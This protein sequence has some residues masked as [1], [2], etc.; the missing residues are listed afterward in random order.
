MATDTSARLRELRKHFHK[1]DIGLYVVLTQDEHNSEYTSD[2]DE[3]RA[4]ISG[5]TGSAGT[6]VIS[7]TKAVLATDGRYFLQA[8]KQLS[9]DWQLLKQG[10]KGVPTWSEWAAQEAA[11]TGTNIGVDPKLISYGDVKSL[12]DLLVKKGAK[13]TLVGLETN[14]I[15]AVWGADKPQRSKKPVFELPLEHTGRGFEDKISELRKDIEKLDGTAF[16]VSAL[17]EI[18]WLFNLR[19]EDIAYN[20]VFFSYAIVSPDSATLYIDENKLSEKVRAHLGDDVT[21]KPYQQVF[22]DARKFSV[23]LNEI[24]ATAA[25]KKKLL[26]AN[27]C[28]WALIKALG[29]ADNVKLVNSPVEVAKAAKNETEVNGARTAHVKDGV[30]LIRYLSWLEDALKNGSKMSD[31]EAAMKSLEFRKQME[32]F[33][34]LSFET[35]S[36]SGP[37]AAIIHYSPATDSKEMV[38]INQVYLLDSGGQYLEGTTDTTRTFHFGTPSAEEK[39]AFTLVLKGHIA[40][41]EAVFPEGSNGYM[42]DTLARQHLWKYG[43]DYRHG[44]GHG[45]GAYLNVHEGPIGVG[46][47]PGYRENPF[48]VGNVIS[49]EPGYYEDGKFG[50]R[51]ESVVVVKEKKTLFNFGDVKYFGFETITQVPLCK[52]LMDIDLLTVDEKK[53]VNEYHEQVYETVKSYFSESDSALAW[54]KRETS[55]LA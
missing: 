33:R 38:D 37:N 42:L 10:V 32:N 44:T 46:F 14:L 48:K 11:S 41:A 27:G 4:F 2:A 9:S 51:I 55:P 12:Q 5:F 50:I 43:L 29:G 40:L 53:W 1:N 7:E 8:G 15:D 25:T 22:E 26:A 34:G 23:K 24:N 20:P 19:G 30:A 45:L 31:Y 39:R 18:A 49:N 36:S 17:D 13:G 54:L 28:S 3:R 52:N 35:I 16:V 47:R 21:V 6:A